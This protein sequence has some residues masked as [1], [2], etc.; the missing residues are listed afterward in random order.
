MHQPLPFGFAWSE[1]NTHEDVHER[2]WRSDGAWQ[3]LRAASAGNESKVRLQ[4]SD[5]VVTILSDTKIARERELEST[6]QGCAGMAAITG[7]GMLS[8]SAMA[9]SKNPSL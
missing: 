7:F 9:L 2:G 6:G 1:G 3:P 5:Q 4:E 8:H